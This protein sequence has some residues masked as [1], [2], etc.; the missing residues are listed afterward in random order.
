MRKANQHRYL[1]KK[2]C[3]EIRNLKKG[4]WLFTCKM[5]PKQFGEFW[6]EN[7]ELKELLKYYCVGD[8][9]TIDGSGHSIFGCGCKPI[10]KKYAMFFIAHK[11]G[12]YYDILVQKI[13]DESTGIN[14]D[15]NN[16]WIDYEKY[17]KNYCKRF[18]VKFEG[19]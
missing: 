8:F 7:K 16:I 1:T 2:Q 14:V 17:V 4:D 12:E 10:S 19:F 3:K 5:E 18:N 15:Y 6:V 11:L 9:N 13:T